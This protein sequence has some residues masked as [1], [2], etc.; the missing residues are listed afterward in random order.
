MMHNI[1]VYKIQCM[2]CTEQERGGGGI[3]IYRLFL[4]IHQNFNIL[5]PLSKHA[6]LAGSNYYNSPP[7][8]II[9]DYPI[10]SS[11]SLKCYL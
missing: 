7:H 1:L 10:H 3:Y 5:F 6:E 8:N 2:K 9:M 11:G 4:H